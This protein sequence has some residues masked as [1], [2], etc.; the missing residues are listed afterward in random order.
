LIDALKKPPFSH[1]SHY[2]TDVVGFD[3]MD[4]M[5]GRC[6]VVDCVAGGG[7]DAAAAA[8]AVVGSG[9][10]LAMSDIVDGFDGI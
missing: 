2:V 8:A 3:R 10:F 5:N 6:E 1:R 7:G 4:G 9:S